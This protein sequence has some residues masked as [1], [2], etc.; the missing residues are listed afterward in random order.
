MVSGRPIRVEFLVRMAGHSDTECD[1]AQDE[2]DD[3]PD[4]YSSDEDG[5]EPDP[6]P[7]LAIPSQYQRA[8]LQEEM[9]EE[10]RFE[11][12]SEGELSCR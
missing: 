8:Q 1:I 3:L 7:R 2:N 12:D 4:M 6:H 9:G 10:D 5:D 11:S